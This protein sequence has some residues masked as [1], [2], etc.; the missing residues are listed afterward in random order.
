L[1]HDRFEAVA[2]D[3]RIVARREPPG[4]TVGSN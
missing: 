2:A 3:D 1:D 4:A